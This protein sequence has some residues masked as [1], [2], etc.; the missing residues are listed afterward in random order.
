MYKLSV[1]SIFK[2]ESHSLKEWIEHYLF[3]G[4]EHFYLIN[5]SSTDNFQEILK[6]YIEEGL[7]TLIH[8]DWGHYLGR[9]R[10]ILSHYL[11]PFLKD[12]EWFI[13]VD[14]DEYLWSPINIDL[15][16]T[17]KHCEHISQ[18]QLCHSL[19]GSNGYEKQ[20]EF[21]VKS[22]T[23]RGAEQP[24]LVY[25][26]QKYILNCKYKFKQLNVHFAEF[27]DSNE[28]NL[29]LSHEYFILNHYSCQSREHWLNIKCTR[30]D[31][32]DYTKRTENDFLM[33]DINEV[34][35]L[36][37]WEQNKNMDIYNSN[38]VVENSK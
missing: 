20:P 21:L 23:K 8:T 19:Y 37:L 2:N 26:N 33:Y 18:I 25:G 7:I 13:V 27:D 22:F 10:A 17:L 31:C 29:M 38:Y 3:H 28:N 24:Y 30:G 11:L 14:L 34:E 5:D 15:K 4:V 6:P 9:Q 32:D 12:N 36:G 16:E 35:D 1:G